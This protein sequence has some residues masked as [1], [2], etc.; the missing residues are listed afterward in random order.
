MSDYQA[1]L[2]ENGLKGSYVRAMSEDVSSQMLLN[3]YY[4]V[5]VR[6]SGIEI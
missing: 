6:P 3:D 5:S 4:G 2:N 1:F